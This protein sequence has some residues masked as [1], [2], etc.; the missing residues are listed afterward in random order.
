MVTRRPR[1]GP[2]FGV[3]Q[4]FAGLAVLLCWRARAAWRRMLGGRLAPP[5]SCRPPLG[6]ACAACTG[7]TERC[8][9]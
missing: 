1:S 6:S 4:R 7:S 3:V 8:L 5:A 2:A 9:A